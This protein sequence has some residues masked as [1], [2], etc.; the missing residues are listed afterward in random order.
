MTVATT[1]TRDNQTDHDIER[2]LVPTG[3]NPP[4]LH[5]ALLWSS[6]RLSLSLRKIVST[7]SLIQV[8]KIF[9]G[10]LVGAMSLICAWWA[11]DL[12]M[13]TSVKDFREDCRE[14][15]QNFNLTSTACEEVLRLPLRK[16]PTWRVHLGKATNNPVGE[17]KYHYHRDTSYDG[18]ERSRPR[19]H[20]ACRPAR[21]FCENLHDQL[22]KYFESYRTG[23]RGQG[24]AAIMYG[25]GYRGRH[26]ET[27][28]TFFFPLDQERYE[29]SFGL[30][31]YYETNCNSCR[32][33]L[34]KTII[35]S[36][37]HIEVL[38]VPDQRDNP[39]VFKEIT[40]LMPSDVQEEWWRGC[41]YP[42][43]PAA[44]IRRSALDTLS[45]WHSNI[46]FGTA[47]AFTVF[48]LAM[49]HEVLLGGFARR[50]RWKWQ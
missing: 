2:A 29:S 46:D 26:I 5:N 49:G 41:S 17:S 47:M 8:I 35:G 27:S 18:S 4:G 1:I 7:L 36:V 38:T 32:L 23:I 37:Q 9:I 31:Q 16:P 22:D 11:L 50:T 25:L 42:S 45:T 30:W 24:D 10:A 39:Q 12:A 34:N 3:F 33:W 6:A 43:L 21:P 14:Q 44:P 15:L 19:Q 48:F 40:G 28:V 13:W 20:L